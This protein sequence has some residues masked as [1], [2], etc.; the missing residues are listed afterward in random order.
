[1]AASPT[2][3][4]WSSSIRSYV[5]TGRL[6]RTTSTIPC[7]EHGE[8]LVL[9]TTPW[10]PSHGTHSPNRVNMIEVNSPLREL[11]KAGQLH[12]ARQMFNK[13]SQRDEVSWTIMISGYVSA[14]DPAEALMLFSHMWLQPGLSMDPFVLSVALKAC[15]LNS[16]VKYGEALHGYSVKSSFVNS[17]FVGSA[18]LDMYTKTGKFEEGCRVFDEMPIR[19]VVSW[20]AIITGLVRAGCNQEALLYFSEMWRSR[21]VCDS[22]TFAIALKASAVSGCLNYGREIH[23]QILKRGLEVTSF[24]ANSLATM[25]NKCGKLDYGLC[26]FG[27]MSTPDVVSWT[28]LITSYV[29]L[30]QEEQAI[31]AFIR[32]RESGVNPN[33]FTFAA[34]FSGCA[35]ISRVEWGEQIHAH[36]I[37]LGLADSLSVANSIMSCIL[38]CQ[39]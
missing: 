8:S 32:M 26:L 24:V 6:C 19:N 18:L 38:K 29:Q 15:G 23:S 3:K 14:M 4:I 20:T 21:V 17:V 30:G 39:F 16:S 7:T 25:Y 27:R 13:M 22:Y 35:G 2:A 12:L 33:E 1:M 10:Q 5:N 9:E 37:H 11:V 34:V 31:E 28:T 36:V